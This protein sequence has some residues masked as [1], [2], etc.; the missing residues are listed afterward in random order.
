MVDSS[1][2]LAGISKWLVGSSNISVSWTQQH[3]RYM[4]RAFSIPL[5]A[6]ATCLNTVSPLNKTVLIASTHS[7]SQVLPLWIVSL[8]F[9][10][11]PGFSLI[12]LKAA[13]I[14]LWSPNLTVPSVGCSMPIIRR[15]RVDLPA[16]LDQERQCDHPVQSA[17]ALTKKQNFVVVCTKSLICTHLRPLRGAGESGIAGS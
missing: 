17:D 3:F 7:S 4:R 10:S 1:I 11:S 6:A 9:C 15:S 14:T 13:G 12:L 5:K 2:S 16:P 8:R